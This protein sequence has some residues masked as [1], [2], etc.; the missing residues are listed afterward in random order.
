MAE[1][2]LNPE[3]EVQLMLDSGVFS[4]WGRGETLKI[5]DYIKYVK[6]HKEYIYSYVNMD[7]VPNAS[8]DKG[9]PPTH[10]E[11]ERS[12]KQSYKNFVKMKD[13]GLNPIPVFHQGEPFEWLER[14][15]N[16]G[17]EYIGISTWKT[18]IT[19]EAQQKWLDQ[20]F[21][22]LTD[23]SGKP[24]CKTHGFGISAPRLVI[25]YPWFT[26]DSTTW[27]LGSGYGKIYAPIYTNGKPDYWQPA[28]N[29]IMSG[30][31]QSTK[32][33]SKMQFENLGETTQECI[34]RFVEEEVGSTIAEVRNIPYV[35][36][37]ALIIYYLKMC[38]AL[39]GVR[40]LEKQAG[41]FSTPKLNLKKKFKM[42]W[43][44]VTLMFATNLSKMHSKVLTESGA[45]TRLL[46]YYEL[47]DKD[48][49]ILSR[50]VRTGEP[51]EFVETI[52]KPNWNS[53]A[54]KVQRM[55]RFLDRLKETSDA[56]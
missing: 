23:A 33:A 19:Q 43:E 26:L 49:E 18:N 52:I 17:E 29:I 38:A 46:S 5:K 56:S 3:F 27:A 1:L 20:V 55:Q 8:D 16:E 37:K 39:K 13:A 40:F 42:D 35:R 9:S 7:I 10:K 51:K 15:L 22:L 14:L 53:E 50:Y 21:T 36:R 28:L 24:L 25:R 41:F 48:D 4:A 31:P 34:R 12:A 32:A 6:K 2:N 45:R 30:V 47:R 44:H 11:T 54:Y